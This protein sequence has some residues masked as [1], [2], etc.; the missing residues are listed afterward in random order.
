[1]FDFFRKPVEFSRPPVLT[2]TNTYKKGGIKWYD[3]WVDYKK[4][5]KLT[6]HIVGRVAVLDDTAKVTNDYLIGS[7][8]TVYDF[9][10]EGGVSSYHG[11]HVGGII[12]SKNHGLF[13][14]AKIGMFK[15]LSA[16]N[17]KGTSNWLVKGVQAAAQEGY[18][19]I[20]ASLGSKV[21]DR[22]VRSAVLNFCKNPKCFVVA[23][24]GN[25]S[26]STD[27]PA[28]LSTVSKG[29]I[30]VG[31]LALDHDTLIIPTFSNFGKVT[32]VAPAVDIVSTFPNNQEEALT[33]TSMATPFIAGLIATCKAINPNFSQD[34]F[35]SLLEKFS[36]KVEGVSDDKQGHGFIQISDML[37]EV[38]T[39][40]IKAPQISAPTKKRWC[41]IFS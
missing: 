33:G 20:N 27:S 39:M 5:Q 26:T 10:L 19:V 22:G 35:H 38:L 12:S 29:V 9:T 40:D 28:S 13:P 34:T 6:S 7:I 21:E 25:D 1:M 30:A 4:I 3:S 37:Q 32:I 11:H 23:A 18:E 2:S 8:E 17:G 41:K 15:V 16:Q 31:A 36:Q 24:T 14:K